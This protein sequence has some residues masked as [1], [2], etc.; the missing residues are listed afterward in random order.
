LGLNLGTGIKEW[1][2]GKMLNAKTHKSRNL[3]KH[4]LRLYVTL[5]HFSGTFQSHLWIE[6]HALLLTMQLWI[7][8]EAFLDL[9]R[10]ISEHLCKKRTCTSL[11]IDYATLDLFSSSSEA[12]FNHIIA[13]KDMYMPL[14]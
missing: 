11:S 13:K 10:S 1:M 5:N 3:P 14:Y 4:D 6:G 8:S 9:F 2:V 7:H 12:L